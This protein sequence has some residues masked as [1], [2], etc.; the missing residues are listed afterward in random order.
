[1]TDIHE[2]HDGEERKKE[3][4]HAHQKNVRGHAGQL[5]CVRVVYFCF[6]SLSS[7]SPTNPLLL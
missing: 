3:E 4:V 1:M 6:L 7:L 2:R 5:V